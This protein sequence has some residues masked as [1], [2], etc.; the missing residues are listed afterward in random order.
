MLPVFRR[1]ED[2]FLGDSDHHATG[3]EW[4]VEAPR[5]TWPILDAVRSAASDMGVPAVPDFNTGDNE[6]SSYF[7]VNQK[8]GLRWSAAR[9]FLKPARK[10]PNLRVETGC[11]A[12]RLVMDGARAVGIDYIQNGARLAPFDCGGVVNCL[13]N[14]AWSRGL[15]C[16]INSQGIMQSPVVREHAG[17]P[18]DQVIQTCVAMGW[19]DESFPANAVV[20][21][22][23]S[24][25]EA[26]VF[27]GFD[28]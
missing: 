20:S 9:G 3:G 4:R 1:I 13:V 19:P 8:R 6:G 24:V 16:V 10:R 23:K 2:H 21:T 18:D 27:R 25:D 17:I 5:V 15:G 28:D 14:A 12:D 22:R 26:A 11:L 7:H